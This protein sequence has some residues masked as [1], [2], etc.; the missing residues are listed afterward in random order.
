MK[1]CP[2]CGASLAPEQRFCTGCGFALAGAAAAGAPPSPVPGQPV[3]APQ[4]SAYEQLGSHA[5]AP[6]P[7]PSG[8]KRVRGLVIAGVGVAVLG[9]V[10]V[11]AWQVFGGADTGADKPEDAV[12]EILEAAES[13]D[14]VAA[15]R[16]LNPAES[17]GIDEVYEQLH[18]RL[19]KAGVASKDGV[20]EA[21]AV[22]FDDVETRVRELGDDV[23]IVYLE[24]GTMTV[25][26]KAEEF[27][28][29]LSG[30]ADQVRA[31]LGD[32]WQERIDL[33]DLADDLYIGGE[34]GTGLFVIT[35]KVD[36]K[37]HV[38]PTATAAEYLARDWFGQGGDWSAYADGG[39][40][41][42][43]TADVPQDALQVLAD[44]ARGDD[45]D[46]MLDALP[47]GQGA[48]LRP[49]VE[50]A[51]REL[52]AAGAGFDLAIDEQEVRAGDAKDGLVRVDIDRLTGDLNGKESGDPYPNRF[53]LSGAC[54]ELAT[55]Y[56]EVEQGCTPQW[57]V[58]AS[59][60]SEA[61]V[62]VRETDGGWQVD[63][64]ATAV[65]WLEEIVGNFP[66]SELD[67]LIEAIDNGSADDW[68]ADRLG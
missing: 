30:V 47:S 22:T 6:L 52:E 1:F 2:E 34:P 51:N 17:A 42:P 45:L 41:D 54:A 63:P 24:D 8:R 43:V 62:M 16:M 5:G 46:G 53:T 33:S 66:D 3:G 59:G 13:Q 32:S 19:V 67:S 40:R 50:L 58:D 49:F 15:I 37:W 61:F 44:A 20:F 60:I 36:G 7:P 14:P 65:A 28:A 23:A 9:V 57:L 12:T 64:F 31:E 27:P 56:G 35:V 68:I 25:E 26:L 4:V 38:S 21:G 10:G 55:Y 29:A 11:A 48:L 39:D 18:Q